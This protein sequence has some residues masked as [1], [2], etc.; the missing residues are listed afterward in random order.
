LS[1]TTTA[2]LALACWHP[3]ERQQPPV[4]RQQRLR[5]LP[6]GEAAQKVLLFGREKSSPRGKK[7]SRFQ[8]KKKG[9][10][11]INLHFYG[12]KKKVPSFWEMLSL[13]Q[14]ILSGFGERIE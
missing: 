5:R 4:K 11:S 13:S 8:G 7:A 9:F 12:M 2:T 6:R 1:S 14:S 3:E 10:K